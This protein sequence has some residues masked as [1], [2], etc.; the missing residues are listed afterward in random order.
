MNLLSTICFC[1]K[2]DSS[3]SRSREHIVPESLWP[4]G[5][6]Q[7]PPVLPPGAVCDVCNNRFS[8]L[9]QELQEAL[10]VLKVFVTPITKKGKPPSVVLPNAIIDRTTSGPVLYLN[11]GKTPSLLPNGRKLQPP[12]LRGKGLRDIEVKID[13]VLAKVTFS[14]AMPLHRPPVLQALHKIALEFYAFC[15][16][17]EAV[18]DQSFDPV[19]SYVLTGHPPR[20]VLMPRRSSASLGQE[21]HAVQLL[22]KE[23]LW[24]KVVHIKLCG[25]EF[26]VSLSE[27]LADLREIKCVQGDTFGVLGSL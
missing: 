27:D 23:G 15:R 26:L 20:G 11:A 24:Q 10:G 21:G 18:M 9:E 16:G 13:G 12:P 1:C 17:V 5:P 19:R 22:A 7:L 6:E 2:A 8:R 3:Q 4:E 25:I 14:S